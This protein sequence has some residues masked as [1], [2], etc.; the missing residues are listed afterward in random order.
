M[1]TKGERMNAAYEGWFK[2]LQAL[3]SVALD[4]NDWTGRWHNG[5]T[6]ADALE[7]GPDE[8]H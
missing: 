3:T 7:E 5:Y 2:R 6:P 8:D 4:P 1:S